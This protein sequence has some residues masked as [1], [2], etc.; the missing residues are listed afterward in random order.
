MAVKS[1]N[2]LILP[3]IYAQTFMILGAEVSI[4]K[5][6][7]AKT[8]TPGELIFSDDFDTLDCEVWSHEIT[9]GG[10]DV[11]LPGK[12]NSCCKSGNVPKS[13]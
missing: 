6:N 13:Y 12:R 11:S 2:L 1:C 10:N 3:F 9:L 8:Y 4:T 5:T 7:K